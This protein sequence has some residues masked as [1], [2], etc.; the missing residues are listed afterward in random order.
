V[1]PLLENNWPATIARL[2]QSATHAAE[3]ASILDEVAA[4]DLSGA[5]VDEKETLSIPALCRF[6]VERRNN[7][8]RYWIRQQH[9]RSPTTLVVRQV[10]AHI[11]QAP[12]TCHA[13]VPLGRA[14]I[15]RYRDRLY[16]ARAQS[17]RVIT[18]GNWDMKSPLSIPGSHCIWRTVASVGSGLSQKRLHGRQIAV[19]LRNGGERLRIHGSTYHRTLKKLLQESGIPPWRRNELPLLYVDG[20]LAAVGDRWISDAFAAAPGEPGLVLLVERMN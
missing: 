2:A 6:R 14:E 10:Q 3:A 11:D 17:K 12:K 18:I 8:L 19:R 20:E 1:L 13:A 7:L 4:Q 16:Y 9:G 5:T 15:C